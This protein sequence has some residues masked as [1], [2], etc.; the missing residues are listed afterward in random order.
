MGIGLSIVRGMIEAMGGTVTAQRSGLGGLA[1]I[2][3]LPAAP[4]P[5]AD[6]PA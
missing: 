6:E 5:P 3:D 1:V 2:L 4:A